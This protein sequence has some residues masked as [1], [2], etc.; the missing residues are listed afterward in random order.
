MYIKAHLRMCIFNVYLHAKYQVPVPMY[1]EETDER[2]RVEGVIYMLESIGK[3]QRVIRDGVKYVF[4]LDYDPG[5]MK[6]PGV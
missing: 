1:K 2:S 4:S 3:R 5:H 6:T